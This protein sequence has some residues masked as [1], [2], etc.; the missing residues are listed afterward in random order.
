MP[1]F[2]EHKPGTFSW[3]ELGTTDAD[4]AKR[5]YGELFTWTFEDMPA[6]PGMTYSMASIGGKH[7][8]ALYKMGAEMANVP[9]EWASYITVEN[10]DDVSKKVTANGGKVMKEPFDVM[11]VGRMAVVADPTG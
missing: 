5:F 11:D 4:A 3:M 7:V 6:G 9:P 1:T 2:T 10:V 8:G